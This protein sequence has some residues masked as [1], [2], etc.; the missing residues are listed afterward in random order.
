MGN[1]NSKHVSKHWGTDWFGHPKAGPAWQLQSWTVLARDPKHPHKCEPWM[2]G[3]ALGK[4]EGA[5]HEAEKLVFRLLPGHYWN[6]LQR[7]DQLA[8][9]LAIR[10]SQRARPTNDDIRRLAKIVY[11]IDEIKKA[12]NWDLDVTDPGARQWGDM[13][14]DDALRVANAIQRVQS[15][16][17]FLFSVSYPCAPTE[18]PNQG[19]FDDTP[20][21]SSGGLFG[22]LSG[23]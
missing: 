11:E 1:P 16:A 8:E 17:R 7:L 18:D 15:F 19:A 4:F 2:V 13:N 10:T 9:P 6:D 20:P 23:L 5:N 14:H 12:T 21:P 3:Y 22:F